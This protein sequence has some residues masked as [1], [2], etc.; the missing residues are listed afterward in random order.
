[1]NDTE[2][3]HADRTYNTGKISSVAIED[4]VITITLSDKVANLKDFD[5]GGSWG[6]Y[7]WLGIAVSAG[8]SPV[9][10]LYLEGFCVIAARVAHSA[11][12]SSS[13]VTLLTS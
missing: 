2:A 12:F 5:G 3:A 11:R 10:G 7:N 9:T 1:M 13:T 4:N 6:V 8:I